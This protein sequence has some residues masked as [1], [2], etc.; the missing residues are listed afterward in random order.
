MTDDTLRER[1]SRAINRLAKWRSVFA[2]WQLGTRPDTDP[3]CQ[4]VRDK[5]NT[6]ISL[7]VEV[8]ALTALLVRKGVITEAE[9]MTQMIDECEFMHEVYERRFPGFRATDDG[10]HLE[11]PLAA[12]T[13]RGWKR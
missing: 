10:M 1:Y 2:G 12:E 5:F 4:A 13:M 11:L 7:R 6:M 8:N 9:F 3:E